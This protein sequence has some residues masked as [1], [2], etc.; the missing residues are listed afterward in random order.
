[1]TPCPNLPKGVT[2]PLCGGRYACLQSN[3][4]KAPPP[5]APKPPDEIK[6]K[7]NAQN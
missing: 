4:P 7:Q 3:R 1:M 2:C 5:G 6:E